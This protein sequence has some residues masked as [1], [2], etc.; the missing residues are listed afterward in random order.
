MPERRLTGRLSIIDTVV[1]RETHLVPPF[2]K[3]GLGE[4]LVCRA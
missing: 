2:V 1:K 3:G 4:I